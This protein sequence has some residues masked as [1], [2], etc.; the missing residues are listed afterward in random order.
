MNTIY[1]TKTGNHAG[2]HTSVKN[3]VL[4]YF[5][6]G[7]QGGKKGWSKTKK[8]EVVG[9]I[10]YAKNWFEVT[11]INKKWGMNIAL[12]SAEYLTAGIVKDRYT[13]AY[14]EIR[15]KLDNAGIPE[16]AIKKAFEICPLDYFLCIFGYGSFDVIKLD[17]ILKTPQNIST[18]DYLTSLY[19]LDVSKA[20]EAGI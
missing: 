7:W 14:I 9:Q 13:R 18:R 3:D 1:H 6:E 10:D 20:I 2:W 12:F 15:E 5:N 19:G 11:E 17:E 16:E 4:E 8:F